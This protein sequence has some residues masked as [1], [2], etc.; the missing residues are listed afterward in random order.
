[1]GPTELHFVPVGP[2]PSL[3]KTL[4]WVEWDRRG[5]AGEGIGSETFLVLLPTLSTFISE[6]GGSQ[7][8]GPR[9]QTAWLPTQP[10]LTT[11]LWVSY[12]SS[13][14]LSVLICYMENRNMYSCEDFILQDDLY[15]ALRTVLGT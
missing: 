8:M 9:V 7:G 15:K 13:L 10:S 4:A 14:H 1:M 3:W 12:I 6:R 5:G 2:R 11:W